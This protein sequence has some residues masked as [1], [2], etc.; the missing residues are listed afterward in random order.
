MKN[1]FQA[2]IFGRAAP[3]AAGLF[4]AAALADF[5]REDLLVG[6]AGALVMLL[7][8]W[9]IIRDASKPPPRDRTGASPG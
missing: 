4:P 5:S 6:T 8:L 2:T 3:A 1:P 7:V 9:V